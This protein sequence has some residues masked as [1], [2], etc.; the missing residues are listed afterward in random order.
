MG[1]RK[2]PS[3]VSSREG[4]ALGIRRVV[5]DASLHRDCSED[6]DADLGVG[7]RRRGVS[8]VPDSERRK[9]GRVRPDLQHLPHLYSSRGPL[10]QTTLPWQVSRREAVFDSVP[11]AY[12]LRNRSNYCYLNS[13]AVF[14]HWAMLSAGGQASD[15][16]SLGPAMSVLTRLKKVELAAHATRLEAT[17]STARCHGAG[18][19]RDGSER[20]P[21]GGRM[22]GQMC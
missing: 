13:V 22:A 2:F 21:C 11:P 8:S 6:C 1:P 17:F 12:C 7:E 3:E 10:T 16:G 19:I 20:S 14:L 18:V 4:S 5:G 9:M 15:Y